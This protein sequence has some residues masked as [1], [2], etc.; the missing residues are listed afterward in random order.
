MNIKKYIHDF[1]PEILVSKAIRK[2]FYSKNSLFAKSICLINEKI[3]KNFLLK[4]IN[5]QNDEIKINNKH[6]KHN[7][8]IWTMWWQGMENAPL[9]VQR[10]IETLKEKNPNH[11]V[12]IITRENYDKYV[13]LPEYIIMKLKTNDISITHFSD[14]LRVN[15]LYQYGGIWADSTLF[16]TK[17]IPEEFFNKSFYSINTENYTNDPSHGRWTTFFMESQRGSRLMKFV[18][19]G[20]NDYLKKY[21]QFMDYILFDYF[22]EIGYETDNKIKGLIDN[23]PKNNANVFLLRKYLFNSIGSFNYLSDKETFLYKLSYKDKP[24][25]LTKNGEKTIYSEI[26]K[27]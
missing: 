3:I 9:L 11:K 14:I 24:S 16:V 8:I 26:V 22:I 5:F 10:C 13:N 1:G 2:P 19:E 18:A 6:I 20:F 27:E 21:D 15:L 4:N 23:V 17:S 25:L 7:A 12:I